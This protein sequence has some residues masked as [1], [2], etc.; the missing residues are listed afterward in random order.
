MRLPTERPEG[1]WDI[2][3]FIS[4]VWETTC[5]HL[6]CLNNSQTIASSVLHSDSL[7]PVYARIC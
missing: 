2:G 6:F 5:D 1:C 4:I 3:A 7:V